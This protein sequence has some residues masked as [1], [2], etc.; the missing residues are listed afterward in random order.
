MSANTCSRND[1]NS[2]FC[3][4]FNEIIVSKKDLEFIR[5]PRNNR[6]PR[7]HMLITKENS[8]S[9]QLRDALVTILTSDET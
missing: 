7:D 8:M 6:V 5:L 2:P 3:S 4:S 1:R 9:S